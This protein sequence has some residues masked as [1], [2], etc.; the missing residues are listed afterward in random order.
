MKES[1][2]LDGGLV[3]KGF[4]DRKAL[5]TNFGARGH[6]RPT[7]SGAYLLAFWKHDSVCVANLSVSLL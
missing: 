3:K 7:L 6:V 4:E 2:G 1:R 5:Y